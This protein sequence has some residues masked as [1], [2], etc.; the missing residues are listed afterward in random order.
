M[1]GLSG[2]RWQ[3]RRAL[4]TAAAALATTLRCAAVAVLLVGAGFEGDMSD[5][6]PETDVSAHVIHHQFGKSR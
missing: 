1:L 3:M 4:P 6:L 5:E 2:E